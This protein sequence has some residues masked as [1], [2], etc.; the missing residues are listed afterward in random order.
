MQQPNTIEIDDREQHSGL[1][2]KKAS[3]LLTHFE[4]LEAI[5]TAPGIGPKL[6]SKIHNL[7]KLKTP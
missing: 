6:A 2:P 3:A 4:S 1:G 7:I 5:F